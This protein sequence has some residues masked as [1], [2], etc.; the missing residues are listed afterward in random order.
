MASSSSSSNNNNNQLKPLTARSPFVIIT[1]T[2]VQELRE[3]FKNLNIR[4]MIF[5]PKVWDKYTLTNEIILN[6]HVD[7]CV[8]WNTKWIM[9]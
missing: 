5:E 1:D 9:G 4:S 3:F 8:I 2:R 7:V 6:T